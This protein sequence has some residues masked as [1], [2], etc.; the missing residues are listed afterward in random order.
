MSV[1]DRVE[2]TCPGCGAPVNFNAV[3]SL[4]ADRSPHLR[5]AV[6]D[7]TFQR[8]V[9]GKCNEGFR[10]D[11]EMT[12][13]DV[14]RGQWIAAFPYAKMEQWPTMEA[15]ARATFDRAY[16]PKASAAAREL[17]AGMKPRLTFGWG[18]LREK[19]FIAEAGFDDVILELAKTAMV[20][21]MDNPPVGFGTEL[22]LANVEGDQLVIA[23]I[24]GE[25]EEVREIM[26][27]PRSLYDGIGANLAPWESLRTSLSSG[28]F[29]DVNRLLVVPA[30][31]A[32]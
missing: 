27:V 13:I 12:Y 32:V 25:N 15:Q 22:R 5:A 6:L 19:I 4:N 16:G 11:P 1:F 3:F 2:V 30:E 26:R 18:A 29:V 9:C 14:G 20:R 24:N 28:L 21:G 31:V 7:G 10:L 17:G 23:W 8:E